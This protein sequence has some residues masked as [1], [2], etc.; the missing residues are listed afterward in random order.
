MSV[1]I[2]PL[3]D[4]LVAQLEV[5]ETKTASG[6]Y[7]AQTSKEKPN[8]AKVLAIGKDVKLVKV[9]DRI[10]YKNFSETDVSFNS[11]KYILVKEKDVLATV[12]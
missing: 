11:E 3:S 9:N 5:V 8:V 7:L 4:Y 6:L 10:V 1:N 2:Q 12:K